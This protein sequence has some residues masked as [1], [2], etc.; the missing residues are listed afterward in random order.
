MTNP[1]KTRFE[2]TKAVQ[3]SFSVSN[4]ACRTLLPPDFFTERSSL[5]AP[6]FQS[7]I[8]FKLYFVAPIKSSKPKILINNNIVKINK[9]VQVVKQANYKSKDYH[10]AHH[11]YENRHGFIARFKRGS[12][13]VR[14][15]YNQFMS[16][17]TASSFG[18]YPFLSRKYSHFFAYYLY[19]LKNWKLGPDF[20]LSVDISIDPDKLRSKIRCIGITKAKKTMLCPQSKTPQPYCVHYLKPKSYKA[21]GKIKQASFNFGSKFPDV[22]ECH[23]GRKVRY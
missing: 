5:S 15:T 7:N 23:V 21:K 4:W 3:R 1:I 14:V 22:L 2:I 6:L 9:T 19:P 12:N 20:S 16:M 13:T 18:V 8:S 11:E 10:R 17:Y